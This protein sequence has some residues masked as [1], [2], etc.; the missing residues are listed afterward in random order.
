[1]DSYIN[2]ENLNPIKQHILIKFTPS[3]IVLE[4]TNEKSVMVD[5]DHIVYLNSSI[6][7]KNFFCLAYL[8]NNTNNKYEINGLVLYSKDGSHIDDT[9]REYALKIS[10]E[11]NGINTK[12]VSVSQHTCILCPMQQYIELCQY[13]NTFQGN[14]EKIYQILNEKINHNLE[15]NDQNY[16]LDCLNEQNLNINSYAELANTNQ[17]LVALIQ[18]LCKS[19]HNQHILNNFNPDYRLA[20]D[21]KEFS[22]FLMKNNFSSKQSLKID[23]N[24]ENISETNNLQPLQ[25]ILPYKKRN[26]TQRSNTIETSQCVDSFDKNLLLKK[27]NNNNNINNLNDL[28]IFANKKKP[29][30]NHHQ[31]NMFTLN[32]KIDSSIRRYIFSKIVGTPNNLFINNAKPAFETKQEQQQQQIQQRFLNKYDAIQLWKKVISEQI[33]LIK[34]Q[35]ENKRLR[36]KAL[37]KNLNNDL[38]NRFCY[39]EITPCLNEVDKI[40]QSKLEQETN[41]SVEEIKEIISKGI[42]QSKRGD[43]WFWLMKQ[44]KLKRNKQQQQQLFNSK[45]KLELNYQDLLKQYSIHQHSILLDLGRTFP[46][47]PNFMYQTNEN[48]NKQCSMKFGLGQLALFNVLKAYSLLDQE[49]GYCQGL[50]FVAGFLLIQGLIS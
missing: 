30:T 13:L 23:N 9:I 25:P 34:M 22:F 40:W 42:P 16:L 32:S 3:K 39:L 38:T 47:H 45:L 28:F 14:D 5:Y 26:K 27:S 31:T 44:F 12:R 19:K 24:N 1:M 35:K 36:E 20:N 15:K 17:L 29:L 33:L 37:F 46:N 43:V 50:S 7:N 4:I 11:L 6:T 21:Q 41:V 8:N 18:K 2:Q 48:E 10:T 49:V